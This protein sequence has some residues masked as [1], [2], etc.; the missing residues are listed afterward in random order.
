[1]YGTPGSDTYEETHANINNSTIKTVLDNWYKENL[2]SYASYLA[3]SGFCGDRS[4]A[5]EPNSWYIN[6]TALG[7]GENETNYGTYNRLYLNKNPQF[8]CP[9]NQDLYTTKNSTKGNKALDYPIGLITIDEAMYAGGSNFLGND[10]YYLY[11]GDNY[12]MLSPFVFREL[13]SAIGSVFSDGHLASYYAYRMRS[14]R[15]V[16]NLKSTVEITRGD[17]TISNPYI[18]RTN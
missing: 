13:N 17:G 1:M 6:D 18:I 5:E 2:S 10:E 8:L 9:Q 14:V 12:W 15:P 3:D 11:T 16:I 4:M 7:Y